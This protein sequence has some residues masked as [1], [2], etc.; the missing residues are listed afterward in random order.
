MAF[1]AT[2]VMVTMDETPAEHHAVAEFIDGNGDPTMG[3]C[4]LPNWTCV[5]TTA[6]GCAQMSG[7][8]QGNC[9]VCGGDSDGDGIPDL[10]DPNPNSPPCATC[11]GDMNGD[12][13]VN[14]LDIQPFVNCLLTGDVGQYCLCGDVDH[15]NGVNLADVPAF[16][17]L[18]LS[19]A[20]CP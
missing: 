16:V 4:C 6:N 5:V 3:A 7:V 17:S 10:C 19:G 2:S 11:P 8:Y 15:A 9:T 12:G 14:G 20:V 18:L 13:K 1:G